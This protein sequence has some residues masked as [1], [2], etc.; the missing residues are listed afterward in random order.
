LPK[1]VLDLEKTTRSIASLNQKYGRRLKNE[2]FSITAVEQDS[3]VVVTLYLAT[4]DRSFEYR[5]EA[6]V[7]VDDKLVH[8]REL[9]LDLSLDF[10]DWYLG[11]YFKNE[12]DL[13]LP[14]DWQA[15]KFGDFEVMARGDL[16]NPELDDMADAWLRG[17]LK[18]EA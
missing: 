8:T 16:R 1:P 5:M 3:S 13:L 15:H 18:T 10:L 12:R 4:L 6:A 11:E 7:S 14:L 2:A 9:A 17:D